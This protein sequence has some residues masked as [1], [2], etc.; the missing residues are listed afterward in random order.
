MSGKQKD[1]TS[2]P[3]NAVRG[4]LTL[5]RL[6]FLL[7]GMASLITSVMIALDNGFDPDWGLL[8]ISFVGLAFIMLATYYF[9]EF[10]DYEGDVINRTFIKFSG[11]SRALIDKNVPRGVAR[12]AGWSAVAILVAIA[13]TYLILYF[14]DYPLLLPLA[15]F[16][17]FCG[18]FY[19]HTPFQW[20]YQ[21]I[22]E[23]MIGGCYGVLTFVSGYY[24]TSGVFE[25]EM[26]VIAM[27]ASLTIFSVIAANEFPDYDADKA[28]NKRNLI[29]RLGT[30]RGALVYAAAMTLAY[31][32]MVA[33]VFV[34]I[35]P[36]IAVVGSPVLL[37]CAYAII[38]T[39]KGGYAV[40]EQQLRISGVTLVANL[41]SALLFI[42]VVL[43]W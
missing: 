10:F 9:N 21:G 25:L 1:S 5:S 11:G 12:V 30:K 22:G 8:G 40:R 18:I 34:G 32:F 38:L 36:W 19:S 7:P 42:P 15:L 20:A 24:L 35:S 37:L 26:V 27:P 29:V 41:L 33:S 4:F 14:D 28:V 13:I 43:V 2:N 16:G 6:P 31:P 3:D 39:L 17:A 23:I